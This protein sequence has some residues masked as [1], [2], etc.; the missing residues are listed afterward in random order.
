MDEAGSR[1]SRLADAAIETLAASGLR[2]LTHRAVD[3]AA[4]VAEGSCSYYFRTRQALLTAAVER[5]V[6]VGAADVTSRLHPARVADLD[7]TAATV[8]ELVGHW[9]TAG[10]SRML[11]RYELALEMTRRP[12][13]REAIALTDDRFYRL[14]EDLLAAAGSPEPELRA[15]LF[16]SYLDGLLFKLIVNADGGLTREQI[17]RAVLDLLRSCVNSGS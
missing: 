15:R 4:G 13:L 2:G 14:A 5:L 1:R 11:A 7:R 17:H 12:E 9:T 10:R 3:R 8:T 6:E 16:V